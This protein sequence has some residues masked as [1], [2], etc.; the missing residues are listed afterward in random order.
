MRQFE[1]S[2][3]KALDKLSGEILEADDI[4]K[5]QKDAF[6]IRTQFHTNE[7]ELYCLECL[8]KLNVST[9][10]YDRLHFKHEPKANFCELKDGNLSPEDNDTFSDIL[11]AKESQR[12]KDLKNKIGRS[13][14]NVKGVDK[15]SISIDSHFII[16]G[17]EKRKPDVYCKYLDK[18]IVFEIQL[19]NLSL[20]YILSR[21]NFY[22]KN[23]IYLIWILD[24]FDIHNQGQLERDIKYLVKHENFFHLDESLNDFKLICQYKQPFLTDRNQIHTKWIDKSVSL[25]Q[26]K[27]D[28]VNFQIYYFDLLSNLGKVENEKNNKLEKIQEEKRIQIEEEKLSDAIF[29]S[30]RIIDKIKDHKKR[31]VYYY[32]DVIEL[33][34]KLDDSQLIIFNNKLNI[35]NRDRTKKPALNQWISE[36]TKDDNSFINFIINCQKIKIDINQTEFDGKTVL[37]EIYENINIHKDLP[38]EGILKRGYKITT[39]DDE[40][41]LNLAKKDSEIFDKI[42]LYSFYKKLKNINLIESVKKHFKLIC[43]IES[44]KLKKIVGY[45]YKSTEWIAFANNAI[46][47]YSEYWEYLELAFKKYELWDILIQK[48]EKRKTFQNKLQDLYKNIPNQ[49]FDFEEVFRE[50]YSELLINKTE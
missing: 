44:A 47:N 14:S 33:I 48:D 45:N 8:Q 31:K 13:L 38:I 3:K 9:S 30:E 29:Y 32:N 25:N 20:R 46:H 41:L 4:F 7:V 21:Y 39:K 1:R 10:K 43:I 26:I 5:V 42:L 18:E 49:K 23:G 16:K 34:D 28:D 27:F 24:N 35:L 40:Y 11:F 17:N 37:Q 36:V 50:L 6:E 2:I 22:K 19:S 15:T 12:H